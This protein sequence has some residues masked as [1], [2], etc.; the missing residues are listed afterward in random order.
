MTSAIA[1]QDLPARET[2][3]PDPSGPVQPLDVPTDGEFPLGDGTRLIIRDGEAVI[4]S[5]VDGVPVEASIGDGALS[6]DIDE[7]AASRR[8]SEMAREEA[9]ARL[10]EARQQAERAIENARQ[11]G[12]ESGAGP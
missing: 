4:V 11:S 10:E 1:G 6:L 8:V 9:A 12:Q 3:R 2:P 7:E 5:E